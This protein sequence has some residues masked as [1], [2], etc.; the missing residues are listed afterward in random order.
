MNKVERILVTGVGLLGQA[1]V[2]SFKHSIFIQKSGY[3]L[4]TLSRSPSSLHSQLVK[5]F[6]CDLKDYESIKKVIEEVK[7]TIIFHTA[8]NPNTKIDENNPNGLILDNI[9]GTN[10]LL[11]A[12]TKLEVKPY[13]VFSS[14][15][16][17]YGKFVEG[18]KTKS[19]DNVYPQSIY[20]TTKLACEN[21]L[22]SYV[23]YGIGSI[24]VRLPALV[25]PGGTHGLVADIIKKLKS[26]DKYLNLIGPAPGSKKPYFGAFDAAVF[27]REAAFDAIDRKD[28]VVEAEM[29]MIGPSDSVTVEEVA[30]ILMNAMGIQKEI[31]WNDNNWPGDNR[32]INID[33]NN[34][35]L[36]ES[37]TYIHLMGLLEKGN[38]NNV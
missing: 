6:E 34:S 4:Y 2:Y 30:H 22:A 24:S 23:P 29:A 27:M 35:S 11:L 20:A 18:Y 7:P 8:A 31:V 5:H 13:I 37:K 19:W 14:S 1:I 10:N 26:D 21:L 25:G 3:E 38:I 28:R 9:L 17:V 33:G 12:C 16:T 32:L 15:V 36:F